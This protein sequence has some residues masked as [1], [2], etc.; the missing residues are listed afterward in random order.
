MRGFNDVSSFEERATGTAMGHPLPDLAQ[1][2]SRE[3]VTG[4]HL[5]R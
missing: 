2:E 4:W 5:P 3:R 1:G